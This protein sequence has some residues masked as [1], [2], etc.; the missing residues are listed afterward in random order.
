MEELLKQAQQIADL[1]VKQVKEIDLVLLY[2]SIAQG[3]GHERSDFDMIVVTDEK[4]VVWEF[5]IDDRPIC[6]WSQNWKQIEDS[7]KGTWGYWS[8]G[9]ASIAHAKI[10]WSKSKRVT[11]RFE[12][13]QKQIKD[14]GKATL[15]RA[16]NSYDN[17]YGK[18]WRLQ[19][20]I[21]NQNEL[22]ARLII[23]DIANELVHIL[24]ALNNQ[25]LMNNWGKQLREIAEFDK[26]PNDFVNRY[27][28]LIR[29]SP[30][31]ALPIA[32]E[33]I[34][35][36]NLLLK[37]WIIENNKIS[38]KDIKG[39]VTE[40]PS[41]IEFLNKAKSATEKGDLVAGLYAASDNAEWNLWAFTT[42]QGRI[43][44]RNCFFSTT[45]AITNL[46][47]KYP[48]KMSVLLKS[49]DLIE[50]EEATEQLAQALAEELN[51]RGYKLPVATSFEDGLQ[52]LQI[53]EK[54]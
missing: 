24:S 34:E 40:W 15:Q 26:K 37:E 12:K 11:E 39:I 14:G 42:L 46:S 19:K 44:K 2:G 25:Y 13:F 41:V 21:D 54:K 32:I 18:L 5:V 45:E 49:L 6:L 38:D 35:E 53:D 50:I 43:W 10:L 51:L 31:E 17:L 9:A 47:K 7:A 29:A 16:I 30:S 52:F 33:L 28:N 1:I 22:D 4:E 48:Q 8:V 27:I 3:R 23:W 20:I 36:V